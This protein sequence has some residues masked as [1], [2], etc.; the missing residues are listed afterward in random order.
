[1][2]RKKPGVDVINDVL[3]EILLVQPGSTFAKS[4]LIQYHERGGLSKKQL[5]GLYSKAQKIKGIPP[6]WLATLQAEILKRP[7]RFKSEL[8]AKTPLYT[9]DENV[10]SMIEKILNKYPQHKRALF[11]KSKFDNNEPLSRVEISELEKFIKVIR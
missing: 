4:L 6:N 9:K 3:V 10:G 2:Q 5:E 8:P 7:T 11:F 1:M